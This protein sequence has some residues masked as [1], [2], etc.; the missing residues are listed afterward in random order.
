MAISSFSSF[1]VLPPP[2]PP[3]E[4]KA[5]SP[6]QPEP[7]PEP[8]PEPAAQTLTLKLEPQPASVPPAAAAKPVQPP[9]VPVSY[10]PPPAP[11]AV[12]HAPEPRPAPGLV[13]RVVR[14]WPWVMLTTAAGTGAGYYYHTQQPTPTP[15]A[16]AEVR[17]NQPR[18]EDALR[19]DRVLAR[20]AASLNPAEFAEPLPVDRVGFLRDHLGVTRKSGSSTVELTFDA[21]QLDDGPK[22][23]AA[24]L[25]AYQAD[26]AARPQ[27][28]ADRPAR[29]KALE[30]EIALLEVEKNQ[31]LA[32]APAAPAGPT[33]DPKELAA[34]RERVAGGTAKRDEL[35]R[36]LADL[37]ATIKKIDAVAGKPWAEREAVRVELKLPE[38]G[39]KN[40][41]AELATLTKEK[42]TLRSTRGLGP[43]HPEMRALQARIDRAEREAKETAKNDPLDAHRAAL[44]KKRDAGRDSLDQLATTLTD[45][46]ARLRTLEARA[47]KAPPPMTRPDVS[48]LDARIA[49]LTR[50]RDALRSAAPEEPPSTEVVAAPAATTPAAPDLNRNL[51][52]GGL[53]GLLVGA[54]LALG[55][56]LLGGGAGAPSV[57]GRR[58]GSPLLG[59]LPKVKTDAAAERPTNAGLD[60]L[61]VTFYRPN[62]ADAEAF[63]QVRGRVYG[64][65]AG[66]LHQIIQVTSPTAADGKSVLAANLAV[67]IAQTG[68][69]VLLIDADLRTPRVHQL[70][71]RRAVTA[72]LTSVLNGDATLDAAVVN[73]DVPNLSLLP[74]GPVPADPVDLLGSAKFTELLAEVRPAYDYVV[75]DSGAVLTAPEV[76]PA[77]R[78]ADGVV[79]VV[80]AE[81]EFAADAERAK[82]R[83]AASGTRILGAVENTAP[84]KPV[85]PTLIPTGPPRAAGTAAEAPRK[86]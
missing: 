22:Y 36:S 35:T 18:A 84:G 60:R 26:I 70:M 53:A 58:L 33:V 67:T 1:S 48:A 75:V 86:G 25:A 20:A 63:R 19:S 76:A 34:L 14:K 44:A 8:R 78:L 6:P 29:I 74:C 57:R 40:A 41:A 5:P 47:A 16:T 66:K 52:T 79:M 17:T 85:G 46:E 77:A 13:R 28:G 7:K 10:V 65:L 2:P 4:T 82:D 51:A 11:P 71:N 39:G 21:P 55:A 3:P 42:E 24:V 31:A 30:G 68:R 50:E 54:T 72:G 27:P 23:L 64:A 43:D 83:L 45:D 9:P 61:V 73:S 56:G 12:H 37:D 59:R 49:E 80:R 62:S 38:P 81:R 32:V 69:R 15:H